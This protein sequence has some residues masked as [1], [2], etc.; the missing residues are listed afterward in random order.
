MSDTVTITRA[1][2]RGM[3]TL[4]GDLDSSV[5]RKA[6]EVIASMP[7]QRSIARKGDNAAA[8]MS[9]DELLL[10]VPHDA[11]SQT[12]TDLSGALEGTH[13][14]VADVSDARAIFSVNGPAWREVLAKGAPVDFHSFGTDEVRRTRIG[15]VAAAFWP[16]AQG[17]E[18]ICFA[19][20]ADYMQAWLTTSATEGTLPDI[21][22]R[23]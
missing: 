22:P 7:A 16:T 2:V 1:R 6:V 4:R 18:V 15:Q 21:L 8:W 12:I 14:L 3:I 23:G 19:S 20:V 5:L 11:V 10:M 13:H 9:P 17:A